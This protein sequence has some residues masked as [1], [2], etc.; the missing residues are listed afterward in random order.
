[1]RAYVLIKVETGLEKQVMQS[2][3][4]IPNVRDV[5]VLFGDYDYLI[6]VETRDSETLGRVVTDQ[7]RKVPGVER[8]MTLLVT[9][10]G[11]K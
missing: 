6:E 8:T 2:L 11:K 1:M 4:D 7:I 5:N 3:L 9:S 10:F